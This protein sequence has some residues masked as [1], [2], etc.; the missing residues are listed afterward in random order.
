MMVLQVFE[1]PNLERS[2]YIA[3][4][5]SYLPPVLSTDNTP[6]RATGK[7]TLTEVLFADIGDSAAKSPHLI[8]SCTI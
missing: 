7:E 6:R 2:V 4:Q 8:V 5:L 3:P 1:L